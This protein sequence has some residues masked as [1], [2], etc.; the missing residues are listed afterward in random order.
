M[1]PRP[2]LTTLVIHTW[3]EH[4][5]PRPLS[6]EEK[7]EA[8]ARGRISRSIS[9]DA[10]LL[11]QKAAY[12]SDEDVFPASL[13]HKQHLRGHISRSSTFDDSLAIPVQQ[14][15]TAAARTEVAAC[16]AM[17]RSCS[18]DMSIDVHGRAGAKPLPFCIQS[19]DA[20]SSPLLLTPMESDDESE[21]GPPSM[22]TS[23]V[24]P[25]H[26]GMEALP[27]RPRR[28]H[29]RTN[30]T[31][32]MCLRAASM[33]AKAPN[34]DVK[35]MHGTP[36]VVQTRIRTADSSPVRSRHGRI[37]AHRRRERSAGRPTSLLQESL[38]EQSASFDTGLSA[39]ARGHE[40]M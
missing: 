34:G 26:S 29:R 11:A 19:D 27:P 6:N 3:K 18:V 23:V 17:A 40:A 15:V 14:T 32:G 12:Q 2:P 4:G 33:L 38:L 37:A 9:I 25:P 28:M 35:I 13:S 8:S 5:K 10:A 36:G 24:L 1:P 31:S 30:S 20:F 39:I 16:E 21:H 7:S 22:R